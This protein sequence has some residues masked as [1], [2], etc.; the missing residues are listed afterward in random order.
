M[1]GKVIAKLIS[2]FFHPLLMPTFG[3]WLLFTT[4]Q[5]VAFVVQPAIAKALYI[6][7]FIST[8]V[9]P[10]LSSMLLLFTG[11]ISSLEM[12]TPRERRLPYLLTALYYVMGYYM[13][14]SKIPL[15]GEIS[16]MIL[17]ANLSVVITLILNLFWKVSAH[18][19]AI[20]GLIGAF[21]GIGVFSSATNVHVLALLFGLAGII[22]YARLKLEAHKPLQ[23]YAGYILGFLCEFL[24]FLIMAE[25]M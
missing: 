4:N 11:K 10:V 5:Y 3:L 20:G 6:V 24:L 13:I 12:Q 19:V 22:G 8:F 16:L 25:R 9:F 21:M 15:P 23:V 7:V 17:G 2:Y 1:S 18:A 14:I